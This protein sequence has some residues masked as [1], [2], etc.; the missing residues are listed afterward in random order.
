MLHQ[1][2]LRGISIRKSV[3][4]LQQTRR[5][6]RAVVDCSVGSCVQWWGR[7]RGLITQPSKARSLALLQNEPLAAS[8]NER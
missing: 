3:Q 7:D 6:N 5:L 8:F 1:L 2:I 4:A